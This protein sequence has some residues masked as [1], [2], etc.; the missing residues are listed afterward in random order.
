MIVWEWMISKTN[1][2]LKYY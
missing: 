2:R 1:E